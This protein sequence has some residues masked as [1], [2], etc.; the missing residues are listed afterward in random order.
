MRL[1]KAAKGSSQAEHVVL[2]VIAPIL[3]SQLRA[4]SVRILTLEADEG[5]TWK[6][7]EYCN[8]F[9]PSSTTS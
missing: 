4:A 7:C 9:C 1:Q 2:D 5:L 6:V 3:R 8:T